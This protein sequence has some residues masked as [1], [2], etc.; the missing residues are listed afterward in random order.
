MASTPN[1]S[2]A[3][4]S[5][6][7]K[8]LGPLVGRQA[9]TRSRTSETNGLIRGVIAPFLAVLK[10]RMTLYENSHGK[11]SYMLLEVKWMTCKG[12]YLVVSW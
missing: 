6:A 2:G 9:P 5:A 11:D 12:L 4:T 8:G 1:G 10:S 3:V 7:S